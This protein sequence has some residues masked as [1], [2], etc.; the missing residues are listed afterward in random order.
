VKRAICHDCG[1]KEG[2]LHELGCDMERCPFCGGQLISCSCQ[3]KELGF[4]YIEPIWDHDKM[5]WAEGTHPT[6]GLPE[7]I[8]KNGLPEELQEKW[9]AILEEKGRVPY[10]EWP[11]FCRKCGV[12]WPKMFH[13]P[14]KDWEKYVQISERD[15]MLCHSCYGQIKRWIDKPLLN[16]DEIDI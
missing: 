12:L 9:E 15:K 3:Y 11:N 5:I 4:D 10:I 6:N 2:Q 1:A 7:D 13:V 16:K 8:Y 14:T